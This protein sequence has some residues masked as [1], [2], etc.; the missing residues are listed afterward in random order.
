V[1]EAIFNVG[2]MYVEGTS[3]SELQFNFITVMK[4]EG[5]NARGP[6]ATMRK[7]T[8]HVWYPVVVN[9]Q[10]LVPLPDQGLVVA[11]SIALSV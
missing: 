11:P 4:V 9:G 6:D 7:Y 1:S 5:S 3:V 10:T 2:V 8:C